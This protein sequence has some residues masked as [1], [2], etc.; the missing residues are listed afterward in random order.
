[1][2]SNPQPRY[3]F[4]RPQVSS[5]RRTQRCSDINSPNGNYRAVA[6]EI[7][8]KALEDKV[9]YCRNRDYNSMVSLR[10]PLNVLSLVF[11]FSL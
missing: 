1:M 5:G 7:V 8:A 2:D 9:S 11:C 4:L 6:R 10:F 3:V